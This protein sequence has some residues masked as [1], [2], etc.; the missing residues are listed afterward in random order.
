MAPHPSREPEPHWVHSIDGNTEAQKDSVTHWSLRAPR[1]VCRRGW[2]CSQWCHRFHLQ[3]GV[4]TTW[5]R[6]ASF[7]SREWGSSPGVAPLPPS[8]TVCSDSQPLSESALL[9]KTTGLTG[10]DMWLSQLGRPMETHRGEDV[11]QQTPSCFTPHSSWKTEA[12]LH[13]S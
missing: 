11:R 1:P 13:H 10:C 12:T 3:I 6:V 4:G 7:L 9:D 5:F 8:C 2:L